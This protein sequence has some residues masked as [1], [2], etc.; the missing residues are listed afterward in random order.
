MDFFDYFIQK[1]FDY[2]IIILPFLVQ[3]VDASEDNWNHQVFQ[4]WSWEM[5]GELNSQEQK[6]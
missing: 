4:Q 2:F 5:I 1:Y 3:H 6:P